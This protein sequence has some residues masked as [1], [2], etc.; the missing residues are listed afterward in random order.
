MVHVEQAAEAAVGSKIAALM[1]K[2]AAD[3]IF[4]SNSQDS[5]ITGAKVNQPVQ[6]KPDLGR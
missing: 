5:K 2:A 3:A 6:V 1:S 4:M